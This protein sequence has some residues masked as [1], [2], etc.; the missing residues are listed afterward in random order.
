ME[1]TQ[2]ATQLCTVPTQQDHV[3]RNTNR[4]ISDCCLT[5]SQLN[6]FSHGGTVFTVR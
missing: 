1:P 4:I 6:G 3:F 2:S 5:Q